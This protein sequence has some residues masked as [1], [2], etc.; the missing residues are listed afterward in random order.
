MSK[1]TASQYSAAGVDLVA[2]ADIKL[3]IGDITKSTYSP[4]VMSVSGGFGGVFDAD[5]NSEFLTVSSTDSVGTKMRIAQAMGRHDT[6][7]IDIVNHCVNDILP[8]GAVPLFF[9][10]YIG[11]GSY[12]A[13]IVE[14]ILTGLAVA[15]RENGCALIGGETA[16]LPGIYHGQDY[17]LVGFIIGRVRRDEVLQP[18]SVAPGDVLLALPSSG[19]HTNGYSLIRSIFDIDSDAAVLD[20]EVPNDGRTLGEA[21]LEPHRSY[22]NQLLPVLRKVKSLA[23][24]TGGSFAK[25]VPRALP[26][27]LGAKL[28]CSS[29]TVPPLFDYIQT[30]GSIDTV[31][32]Y[33]VFNMGVGMIVCASPD[34]VDYLLGALDDA[35]I[36]GEASE[37]DGVDDRVAWV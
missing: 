1:V 33:N 18:E 4:Q 5:A 19:L 32:M 26:D 34:D 28:Q 25:N 17:D 31:E 11:L 23:H 36:I 10:D 30:Q 37:F 27:G 24:I 12:D 13:N 20:G 14:Q 2:A 7:G 16:A 29:W 35:W 8:A 6:I 9:L 15:C 3:R 22:L 21:L